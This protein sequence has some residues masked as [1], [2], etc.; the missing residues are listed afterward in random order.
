MKHTIAISILLMA[1]PALAD[2]IM[3]SVPRKETIQAV[4]KFLR[5]SQE[6]ILGVVC[7]TKQCLI[8]KENLNGR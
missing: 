1:A 7:D 6:K 4:S 2:P 8:Y 5:G 3:V